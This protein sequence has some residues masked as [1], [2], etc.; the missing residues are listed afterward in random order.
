MLFDGASGSGTLAIL[1]VALVLDGVLP[2]RRWPFSRPGH[3]VRIVGAVIAHL[4]GALNRPGQGPRSAIA[5]GGVV[6]AFVVAGSGLFGFA[7]H[8]IGKAVLLGWAVELVAV[9]ALLAQRSLFG[10][11]RRVERELARDN[12]AAA[13]QA[14]AHIVGRDPQSLDRHGVARAATESLVENFSDGAIAPALFYALFGL[15]GLFAYKAANTLDSM[16]GHRSPRYLFFGRISARLDDALNFVPARL[17]AALLICAAFVVP[18]A[19]PGRAFSTAWRDAGKHRSINAGWP[20]AAAAGALGL[21]LAGPRRYGAQTV[22]DP[23]LGDGTPDV[24]ARD[25]AR[26]LRLYVAACALFAFLVATAAVWRG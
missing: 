7:L 1:A 17:S 26:A 18:G 12:L 11:V 22:D 8:A 2:E 9:V 21:A 10:H 6:A 23:W 15:P 20:E 3:P 14:V 24:K 4:D 25:V 16:I 13:R 5:W 19:R